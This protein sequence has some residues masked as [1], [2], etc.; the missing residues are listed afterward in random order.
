M[1]DGAAVIVTGATREPG[2]TL[3]AALAAA[4]ANVAA[5]D[6]S[7]EL[8]Q[9]LAVEVAG[10]GAPGR[11]LAMAAELAQPGMCRRVV[12][13]ATLAFAEIGGLAIDAAG[14]GANPAAPDETPDPFRDYAADRAAP[15]A[16]IDIALSLAAPAVRQFRARGRGRLVFAAMAEP[17]AALRRRIAGWAAALDGSGVTANLLLAGGAD[18]AQIATA[19]RWLM[20]DASGG[21]NGQCLAAGR[22]DAAMPPDEAARR[23]SAPIA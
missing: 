23:A 4:G 13:R 15:A 14:D 5:V 6:G 19:A 18:G 8:L 17:D 22:W 10:Q 12:S 16:P 1:L 21:F 2:R 11:V 20:S 3:V 7:Q 9:A